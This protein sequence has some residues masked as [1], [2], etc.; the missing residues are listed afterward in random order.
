VIVVVVVVGFT[1]A[2]SKTSGSSTDARH[3]LFAGPLG[4][5]RRKGRQKS[6]PPSDWE[7]LAVLDYD[8]D[9]DDDYGTAEEPRFS[10]S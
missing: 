9:D 4:N 8:N 2:F 6:T 3:S 5:P 7:A 10:G 1:H